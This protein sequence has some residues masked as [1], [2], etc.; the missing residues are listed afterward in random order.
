L[1]VL[2]EVV[3]RYENTNIQQKRTYIH[4]YRTNAHHFIL[5]QPWIFLLSPIFSKT[6]GSV[7]LIIAILGLCEAFRPYLYQLTLATKCIAI[8]GALY[9]WAHNSFVLGATKLISTLEHFEWY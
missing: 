6:L 8:T 5:V 7:N 9:K 4:S 1:A 2:G 3:F